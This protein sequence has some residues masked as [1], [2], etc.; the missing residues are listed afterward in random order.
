LAAQWYSACQPCSRL[1]VW[2]LAL[3]TFSQ[4]FHWKKPRQSKTYFYAKPQRK[5]DGSSPHLSKKSPFYRY[6]FV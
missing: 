5:R 1:C 3:M 2:S 4:N 6:K